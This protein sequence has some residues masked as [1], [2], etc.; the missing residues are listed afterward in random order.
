MGM[1]NEVRL[2]SDNLLPVLFIAGAIITFIAGI[3]LLFY[4][5][6]G[7][8]HCMNLSYLPC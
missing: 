7:P 8:G 4:H 5:F 3:A 1:E 6:A 2:D